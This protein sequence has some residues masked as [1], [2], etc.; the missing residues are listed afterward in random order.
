MRMSAFASNVST[1]VLPRAARPSEGEPP[2]DRLRR[3][4]RGAVRGLWAAVAALVV[5]AVCVGPPAAT[6]ASKWLLRVGR[7]AGEQALSWARGGAR[8]AWEAALALRAW[9]ATVAPPAAALASG[10]LSGLSHLAHRRARSAKQRALRLLEA[11]E[12]V[13][14]ANR[15]SLQRPLPRR[16]QAPPAQAPDTS[17]L[18]RNRFLALGSLAAVF[19]L[20]L[21]I[22]LSNLGASPAGAPNLATRR[23]ARLALQG[24]LHKAQAR[25]TAGAT[26]RGSG[27]SPGGRLP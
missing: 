16:L 23:H 7:T 10:R 13:R 11:I 18:T 3:L 12:E 15:A 4:V 25:A 8:R 2:T 27:G 21:T 17:Q 1:S 5:F 24:A 9:L 6:Y 14:V 26:K 20:A 22:V 19:A